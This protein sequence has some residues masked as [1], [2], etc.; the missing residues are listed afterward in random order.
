MEE[1]AEYLDNI[2]ERMR[3]KASVKE[4]GLYNRLDEADAHLKKLSEG[5]NGDPI[6]V[7]KNRLNYLISN[8]RSDLSI[9]QQNNTDIYVVEMTSKFLREYFK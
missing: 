1:L 9:V 2:A 5:R 8:S 6:E 4:A 3:K 7:A